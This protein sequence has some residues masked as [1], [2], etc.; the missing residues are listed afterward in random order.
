M[1]NGEKHRQNCPRERKFNSYVKGTLNT[2][3]IKN[4]ST[5]ERNGRSS[6][7]KEALENNG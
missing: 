1:P 2:D 3:A 7:T 4:L 6:R 5:D